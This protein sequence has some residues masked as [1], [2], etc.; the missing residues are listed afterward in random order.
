MTN[1]RGTLDNDNRPGGD[2]PV[3][4]GGQRRRLRLVGVPKPVARARTFTA[5]ALADWSWPADPPDRHHDIV[6]LAAEFVANAAMHAGGPREIV[7]ELSEGGLRIE[8]SDG[9]TV[10]PA[11]QSP[12]RPG[13]PGG[14]GLFIVKQTADRWGAETYDQGKTV[15]AEID[16]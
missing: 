6:L 10:L 7:L 5:E 8:V 9:S 12:H 14:H 2:R 1:S 11:P 16:A 3:P 4:P 15:W 13:M